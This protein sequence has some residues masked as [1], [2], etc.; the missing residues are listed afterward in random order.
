MR[1]AIGLAAVL[2]FTLA[3]G[4]A[5]AQ[6]MV[7]TS[8][9]GTTQDAQ[10]KDWAVPFTRR[11]G[12]R[13]VQ[14]GPTNYGKFKAM[15]Q[16]GNVSWDVVDVEYDFAV[17]A[18]KDGLLAPLD[19]PAQ[20]AARIVPGFLTRYAVGSFYYS[21]VIG[22]DAGHWRGRAPRTLADLFDTR[23]FPGKRAFYKWS[24]PG[25]LEAALLADGVPPAKLYPLDLN[26]AFRKLDT[27]KKDIVWWGSGAQSQ[28]LLA[29]GEAPIGLFWNGRVQ[30]LIQSGQKVA[31]DWTQNLT[32]G[33]VL[34]IPRG[35]PHLAAARRFIAYATSAK[36]QAAF[37]TDTGYAPI[38]QGS[39]ALMAKTALP[40][41]PDSHAAGHVP[42]DMQ[43]WADHRDQIAS[44][45]YAWQTK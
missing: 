3:S 21:F 34:V 5:L 13:V 33:D 40:E 35:A 43:Y 36:A 6:T 14:D 10:K 24:A 29:S 12:I 27:I 17:R 32:T 44:R 38:N 45:W 25:L 8:W 11:T 20:D 18:A 28:Q 2:A 23:R 16:A 37:A 30:A 1:R 42:L 26:R 31:I 15:V 22:Y 7:F 41:L 39:I 9:G 4:A 19:L